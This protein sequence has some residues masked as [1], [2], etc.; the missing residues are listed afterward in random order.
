M[1]GGNQRRPKAGAASD[2]TR[3]LHHTI[4]KNCTGLNGSSL[5][6]LITGFPGSLYTPPAFR[7]LSSRAQDVQVRKEGPQPHTRFSLRA[8]LVTARDSLHRTKA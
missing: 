3:L 4:S 1:E 5:E 6:S 8:P 7:D 2:A